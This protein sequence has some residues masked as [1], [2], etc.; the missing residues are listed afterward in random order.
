MRSDGDFNL[1]VLGKGRKRR[2]VPMPKRIIEEI[3]GSALEG[4]SGPVF[5]VGL[6]ISPH[7]DRPF[8]NIVISRFTYRDH[9]FHAW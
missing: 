2:T 4:K 3:A 7:R 8:H 1:S 5:S 9:P 6:R